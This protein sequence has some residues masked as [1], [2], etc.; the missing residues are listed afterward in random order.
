[1]LF[2]SHLLSRYLIS[3]S[4]TC[5]L[6]SKILDLLLK[7]ARPTFTFSRSTA[8]NLAVRILRSGVVLWGMLIHSPTVPS[9]ILASFA[10][11]E[12]SCNPG[13]IGGA[14][15]QGIMQI[16]KEKCRGAPAGNCLDP[17]FNIRAG[18]KYFAE[19]LKNNHGDLLKSIGM[20]NGWHTGM[21]YVRLYL[22]FLSSRSKMY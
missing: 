17:D 12:S 18:A 16:T 8:T 5:R 21:T 19:T 15:E 3:C 13:T 10:L 11:Q 6:L 1:M 9:I 2:R 22:P 14:G 4:S 7:L 20:Y